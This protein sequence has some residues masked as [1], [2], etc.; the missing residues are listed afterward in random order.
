MECIYPVNH[1]ALSVSNIHKAIDF[2]KNVF[3]FE[4]ISLY[5][6]T[7][8]VGHGGKICSDLFPGF[9]SV[10]IAHLRTA[11]G[12]GIELFEFKDAERGVTEYWKTGIIHV[13]FTVPNL[14]EILEKIK[15]FG[16][17]IKSKI[18]EVYPGCKIVYTEDPDGN[19]IELNNKSYEAIH[20]NRER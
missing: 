18:W 1:V 19:I 14:E 7:A 12:V 5:E 10:K 20:C 15:K 17:K 11:N 2:Y 16:G 6:I 9:K 4:L 8:D 3:G 13:S